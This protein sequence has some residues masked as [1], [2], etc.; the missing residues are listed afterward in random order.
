[1]AVVIGI[2][3][4]A[5]HREV[6]EDAARTVAGVNLQWITYEREQDIRRQVEEL[7]SRERIDGLL[8]GL[9]P[10]AKCGDLLPPDLPVALTTSAGLDL[11]LA[12]VRALS[13][14]LSPTPVSIDTFDR[15]TVE[16]IAQALQL[17][18]EQIA[19]L[20]YAP[21]QSV[22]D[23]SAFHRR[24]LD[25]ARGG[26]VVTL[27]TGVVAE[28]G[29]SLP[30]LTA[31]PGPTTIRA[32][33][34]ELVLRVQSQRAS[35][36]RFAAGVFLVRQDGVADLDRARVGLMNMLVNTPG[37]AEAWIENRG[38][39]GV[40]VFAH[41]AL[42]ERI[43]HNWVSMPTLVQAEEALGI[44][45]AA[46]FGV[47]ASARNCV[48]LAER[49]AARAEQESLPCGFMIEDSGVIIGPM[50]PAGSPLAFTYRQHGE[51]IEELAH[52][53]GLSPATLSRLVAVERTLDGK[54]ISP[55]DLAE[56]LGITDPSGRRLIRKLSESG[57]VTAEGSA[58]VHR[59][60][61]PT[62]LFRLE[63]GAAIKDRG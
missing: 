43:T 11:S 63:I 35:A 17:D 52:E 10:Y 50:G 2:V 7:L 18:P 3:I 38:R 61:R 54:A 56:S 60:G 4:H 14:G 25:E 21:E 58:Q 40:V 12:F 29:E 45:M 46:G 62:R 27:R 41:Q 5:S 24:F 48:L 57:L 16:E 33:L 13:R 39:R 51:G 8:L 32:D 9:V 55:S 22:T 53:V 36:L 26:Y 15:E 19:C 31:M 42:F 30:V 44:R 37:F 6:F 20:P 34:H 47:G 28:L 1:M 23:I 49:A 59:K